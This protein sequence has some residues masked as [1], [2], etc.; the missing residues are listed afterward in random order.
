MIMYYKLD[1]YFLL[2]FLLFILNA[3]VC[4]ACLAQ[5]VVDA[6]TQGSSA[7]N[8]APSA[9]NTSLHGQVDLTNINGSTETDGLTVGSGRLEFAK[10]DQY[11]QFIEDWLRKT[12]P[13]FAEARKQEDLNKVVLISRSAD[14]IG[15]VLKDF[16]V[17]YTNIILETSGSHN[18]TSVHKKALNKVP[19]DS[20]KVIILTCG[21]S[22][23]KDEDCRN[24]PRQDELSQNVKQKL[25]D[26]VERGGLLITTGYSIFDI[27][28]VFPGFIKAQDAW[29]SPRR[30]L[31]NIVLPLKMIYT[32]NKIAS[33]EKHWEIRAINSDSS[34]FTGISQTMLVS[35]GVFCLVPIV[36]HVLAPEKVQILAVCDGLAKYDTNGQGIVAV[37]FPVGKGHILHFVSHLNYADHTIGLIIPKLKWEISLPRFL[38]I[39]A[40]IQALTA[41][42]V[43]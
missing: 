4:Q 28:R 1:K 31:T 35:K 11:K 5:I 34:L 32:I 26:F 38:A 25:H 42:T 39:N 2:F 10:H 37:T 36:I 24:L 17:S 41:G 13:E 18:S 43:I 29:K 20:A 9:G 19:W 7:E 6:I 22:Y 15:G 16:G 33:L 23:N 40:I 14:P 12:H 3:F 27:E 30:N 21:E 8:S